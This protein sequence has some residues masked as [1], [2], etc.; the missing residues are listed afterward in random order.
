MVVAA[1]T[2][3]AAAAE[4]YAAWRLMRYIIRLNSFRAIDALSAP[5]AEQGRL[6]E[7]IAYSEVIL[8]VWVAIAWLVA[9]LLA[10]AGLWMLARRRFAWRLGWTGAIATI[11]G[12]LVTVVAAD[13]M[14]RYGGYPPLPAWTCAK[15]FLVQSAPGWALLAVWLVGRLFSR[16]AQ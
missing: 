7:Q 9:G 15:G 4:A 5:Q 11:V 6:F 12:G 1:L 16:S 2:V 13:L 3:A 8:H 14:I 10:V